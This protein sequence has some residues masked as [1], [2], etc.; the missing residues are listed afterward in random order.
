MIVKND[1]DLDKLSGE[2]KEGVKSSDGAFIGKNKDGKATI[3]INQQVAA[4]AGAT[5]VVGHELLHYMISRKFK[6]DNK[7]MEPLVGELKNYLQ[8]NHSEVYSK[9]Q[10]RIDKFYTDKKTGEIKDGALEEY[11]NVFSDLISK[12]K[13]NI[14]ESGS[15]G[16]TKGLKNIMTGFGFGNVKLETAEDVINFLST[17]E[18]NINRKG[19]LGKLM[20][21]K[22][23]DVGLES[24]KLEKVEET[25]EQEVLKESR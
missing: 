15:K 25:K 23:L 12:E 3:Y 7:S 8:K 19:L 6:T 4:L 10:R 5:N 24:S 21:T 22:I 11:L 13:I 14:N 17:Y 20:G 18:K 16:F 1:K 9:V 2:N